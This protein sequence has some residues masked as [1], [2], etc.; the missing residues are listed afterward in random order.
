M[1]SC[2]GEL[3]YVSIYGTDIRYTGLVL[4]LRVT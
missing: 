4:A 1:L 3:A 2:V